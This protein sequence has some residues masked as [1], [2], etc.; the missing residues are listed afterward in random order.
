MALD[1]A[2]AQ[3]EHV[4]YLLGGAL[5]DVAQREHLLLPRRKLLERAPHRLAVLPPEGFLFRCE[6]ATR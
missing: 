1:T 5:L 6:A 3:T 4:R 2:G